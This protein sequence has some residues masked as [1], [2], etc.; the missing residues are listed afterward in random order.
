MNRQR[1]RWMALAAGW[2]F[3]LL[4]FVGLFLPVLQGILFIMI[5]LVILSSEY[6][7]ASNLLGKVSSRFPTA[8]AR[9]QQATDK[10][11]S[12]MGRGRCDS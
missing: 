6:I 10:A 3:L 4:G 1:K 12:W 5:G 8:A 9:M 2:G 11:R 7:W